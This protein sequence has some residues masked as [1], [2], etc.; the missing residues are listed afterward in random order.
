MDNKIL[1]TAKFT[2]HDLKFHKAWWKSDKRC[3]S[4]SGQTDG[5]RDR[6]IPMQPLK[7]IK[8]IQGNDY[9]FQCSTLR[10]TQ[11]IQ[12]WQ[13]GDSLWMGSHQVIIKKACLWTIVGVGFELPH[14]LYIKDCL[15][16]F[17][18]KSVI[19]QSLH[20]DIEIYQIISSSITIFL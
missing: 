5:E 18:E 4:W 13:T 11:H 6:P 3:G 8:Y 1:Y 10:V 14:S 2:H 20:L 16:R 12:K 17:L 7:L 19:T 15:C 9:G